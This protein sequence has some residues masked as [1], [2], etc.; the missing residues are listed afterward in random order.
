MLSCF[1]N[2]MRNTIASFAILLF[3][4]QPLHSLRQTKYT[5]ASAKL[6][7]SSLLSSCCDHLLVLQYGMLANAPQ[8]ISIDLRSKT[9]E[10]RRRDRELAEWKKNTNAEARKVELVWNGIFIGFWGVQLRLTPF[11]LSNEFCAHLPQLMDELRRNDETVKHYVHEHIKIF[12]WRFSSRFEYHTYTHNT[13]IL[14]NI[15]KYRK[16]TLH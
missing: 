16:F 5:F 14:C 2:D 12:T 9:V 6:F 7:R 1:T 8:V 3:S 4:F 11:N 13:R 10:E 15:R